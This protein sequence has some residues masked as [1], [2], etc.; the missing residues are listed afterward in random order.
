MKVLLVNGS[1][2]EHGCTYTALKEVADTLNAENVE[3]EI[4]WLGNTPIND[5]KGCGYC[6]TKG[7]CVTGDDIVNDVG[8]TLEQYDGF[9]FG[10]PVYYSGPDA[11]LCA[12]MDRL[13]YAFGGKLQYKPFA[14][15]VSCRRSGSTSSFERLNQFALILNMPVVPSQYWNAVHGN[16]PEEVMQ[17]LEGLQTMRTLG[18]NM[19]WMLRCFEAGKKN[20]IEPPAGA[21]EHIFTN[22]VR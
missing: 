4:L 9:V 13:F 22:F 8:S 19:A 18:R 1:P 21:E 7:R 15:V 16:R 6:K 12:F 10:S 20:G 2:H 5:C 11:R 3:T 17:D 14:S